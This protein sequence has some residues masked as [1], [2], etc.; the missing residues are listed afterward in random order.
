MTSDSTP[1]LGRT[2]KLKIPCI[3]DF[4]NFYDDMFYVKELIYDGHSFVTRAP[5]VALQYRAKLS[6]VAL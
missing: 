2:L 3:S 5:L 4:V 6:H 1:N